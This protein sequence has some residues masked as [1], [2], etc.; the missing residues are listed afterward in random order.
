MIARLTQIQLLRAIAAL[1]VL[2]A[3]LGVVEAKYAIDPILPNWL[4]TGFAGV[5]LFFVI[6]G[7]IMARLADEAARGPGVAGAFIL[8]RAGRIY[9]LYWVVTAVV[10]AIWLV[11]P[12]MVFASNAAPDL[13]RSF[14]LLP[15]E[16]PPILA[17][18]WTLVHEMYFYAIFALILLLPQTAFFPALLI[19]AALVVGGQFARI[20]A[21]SP[22]ASIVF[23]PLTFEFI[24][25]AVAGF[26]F[27]RY[28]SR[29]GAMALVLGVAGMATAIG[30][31]FATGLWSDSAFWNGSW[32]RPALFA[33][34]GALLVFGLAA[35]DTIG[36]S[37]PPLL[38]HLG[39][40]SYALYLTHVLSLSAVGR[41]WQA[42][43]Q[44]ASPMDNVIALFVMVLVA[45]I[46]AE[47]AFRLVDKPTHNLVRA[48][49]RGLKPQRRAAS[50]GM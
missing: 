12:D 17:V 34:P 19:W 30:V 28:A 31:L 24:A 50:E 4:S 13:F 11:R 15:D 10:T 38:A 8:A 47:I 43:P 6:S 45:Y 5:D 29:L 18:G 25:G 44:F 26:G 40:Q 41:A 20:G 39:D 42:I 35:R 27:P 14:L 48:L 22:E 32:L 21:A 23:H 49:T 36:R 33:A 46:A 2:V 16:A 7:F 37:A 1:L 3:H 9:P